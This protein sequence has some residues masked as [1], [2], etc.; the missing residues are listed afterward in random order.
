[1]KKVGT[2]RSSERG[3]AMVVVLVVLMALFV[4]CAPFLLTVRNADRASAQM[5]DRA[6]GRIAIDSATRHARANL[7]QSH[8]AIDETPYFDGLDELFVANEFP[9]AFLDA[10]DPNGV[11]WD[12]DVEDEAGRIDLNSAGPQ[13][14]AN[15]VGCVSRLTSTVSPDDLEFPVSSTAGFHE[16]GFFFVGAELI[17]FAERKPAV[18]G[19][20]TRE[21]GVKYDAEL[22]P[23]PCGPNVKSNHDMGSFVIDQRAFAIPD[24]R[25][26][27]GEPGALARFD[28]IEQVARCV[29]FAMAGELGDDFVPALERTT[30]VYGDV[31]AGARWFHG[32]KLMG[33]VQGKPDYGCV[34]PIEDARN[35]NQGTTVM[36][37]DGV[38]VE[39][40]L[41][42][43]FEQGQLRL[44]N[45]LALEYQ[46]FEA[47]IYP[48]AR[49]PVNVNTASPEVLLALFVNLKLDGHSSRITLSE[50]E[51]L[52]K[53]VAVSRP[54]TGFEDF[55]RRVVLPAAGLAALPKDAPVVPEVFQ[56]L[57]QVGE[58]K[59]DGTRELVGFLDEDDARALYKNALNANDVELE[60]STM[61]FSFTSRDV[62][63]LDLRASVNA[64]SGVERAR[65]SREEIDLVVPQRDLLH[66]WA[67]QEDFDEEPR[68]DGEAPG[69][70]TGPEAT[71]RFDRM[72][73]T[74]WPSRA[75]AHLGRWDT[76]VPI[77]PPPAPSPEGEETEPVLTFASREDGLAW[78]QLAPS[79]ED[80]R[81]A[82]NGRVLHFDDE[83]EHIEGRYLPF[84]TLTDP[85]GDYN[86][87]S[88]PGL[89]PITWKGWIQPR[90]LVPGDRFLDVGG[91]FTDSDRVSLFLE[92]GDLVLRVLDAMGDHPASSFEEFAEVRY[93]LAGAGP[94]LL[95]DVWSHVE[96]GVAGTRP[97]Q[98]RL[99]VDGR[100]S[101][102]TPGLTRLASTITS[103][104]RSIPVESTEG[105]PDRCVIRIGDE[106]IEVTK[107]GQGAFR[108]V[109]ETVGENAGFGGRLARERYTL[110][111][112][113]NAGLGK[114]TDHQRGATVQLYGYSLPLL[115]NVP[116]LGGALAEPI[117]PFAAARVVY[118]GAD[119]K[120]NE[121]IYVLD[122]STN[123]RYEI[124]K[125]LAG[126]QNPEVLTLE[127]IDGRSIEETMAAFSP[128]GGYAALLSR[129]YTFTGDPLLGGSPTF[130]KDEN[131][132][133][134]GGVEVIRYAGA[135]GSQLLIREREVALPNIQDVVDV[136]GR[137]A[138]V[139]D[140]QGSD[141]NE[142][143][144]PPQPWTERLTH[145][146][147]V[148][149]ISIPVSGA[150]GLSS[151]PFPGN[152][153]SEFVQIT[154]LGTDS[155][156]TEWVRYDE[157]PMRTPGHLVRDEPNALLAA[158]EA[159]HGGILTGESGLTAPPRGGGGQ[160]PN[161]PAQR[162]G[163]ASPAP[164]ST[165]AA[166]SASQGGSTYWHFALGEPEVE[167]EA[168]PA[169]R[170]IASQFQFR[171]VLGTWS[172]AHEKGA[173]VLPVWRTLDN[174]ETSGFPGRHD[175]V[176]LADQEPTQP[177][178]HAIVQHAHRPLEYMAHN[179]RDGSAG[180]LTSEPDASESAD[181]TGF[182]TL[183]IHVALQEALP[184]LF[185]ASALQN[186]I[187]DTRG[188]SRLMAFPSGER[189]RGA[190]VVAVGGDARGAL[191]GAGS[192]STGGG[193]SVPSAVVDELVYARD[194]RDDQLVVGNGNPGGLPT[195][196]FDA[197]EDLEVREVRRSTAGDV[198]DP[199]PIAGL[200]QDA[201]LLRI[202][203]EILCYD[204]YDA[205]A[206][207]LHFPPQGRG[208]LGTLPQTHM[209]GEGVHLLESW[210]VSVL[211]GQ[212]SADTHLVP[213]VSADDF[214]KEGTL[215]IDE[216]LLHFTHL[217]GGLL[218]MPRASLVPGERD[219]RGR[220]LF[221]GRF[222]TEPA[223][224]T[225][226]TPV[227]LFPFRYWDRWEP[228]ADDPELSY[229]EFDV[230][231]PD[232]FWR[233]VFWVDEDPPVSGTTLGVLQRLDPRV[234]WDAEPDRTKGLDLL[235]RGGVDRGGN[236]IGAQADRPQW[237]VFVRYDQDAFDPQNGRLHGWKTTPKLSLFGT[238]YLGPGRV[239]RR[240]DR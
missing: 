227:I 46:P 181:Q 196:F 149:P 160:P 230:D 118:A 27:A 89:V 136:G 93:A 125:G 83:T 173:Q 183:A 207:T 185:A 88:G 177:V 111:P 120:D 133:R 30:T 170:A 104:A 203:T 87:G 146:T 187:V 95:Q 158:N 43:S 113:Q 64:P 62:Y 54:F 2:W 112:E 217:E 86:W 19:G 240:V 37:T 7:G 225:V 215:L 212:M 31:G 117:G 107:D 223:A 4:L 75:K 134:I 8:R 206:N 63:R 71:S 131:D 29:E 165:P 237:R 56:Q 156:L 221:R 144:D 169:T 39:F 195:P 123:A 47:L 84:G 121:T 67:R 59:A 179:Y 3:V 116:N 159:A 161:P 119:K 153:G 122:R 228:L 138:F 92:D 61:P 143:D 22:M 6:T 80:D 97:D 147:L 238:E 205:D 168:F 142:A 36:I 209:P 32:V 186:Q 197:D 190:L 52:V 41:V 94:G 233:S 82:P 25:L 5:A 167:V 11:M 163:L 191:G 60:F 239:L 148:I 162:E 15:L 53:I 234:P 14:L 109:H 96:I 1:M 40:G 200:P 139:L 81:A 103:E 151:F 24:W 188:V 198:H 226:G 55:L 182:Q 69:W 33:E 115:T 106:L 224:H 38:N 114:D 98:M 44:W 70:M 78:I 85:A 204:G 74:P 126:V 229:F 10:S 77:D 45:E 99:I 216:E 154:R 12:L 108:A 21:L 58:L 65:R 137:G 50:A 172:H 28:A 76:Q 171:G 9:E 16:A 218:A 235:L 208:L 101:A 201:G 132:V 231:Q 140:W 180:P 34:L 145:Q 57:S 135:R 199:Q 66:V 210:R 192:R 49:R 219:G 72:F 91:L 194:T 155:H 124:G 102:R 213:V 236:P 73:E 214:P 23:L 152:G 110:D 232:A 18:L 220:G 68:L 189:P 184:V 150:T 130:D 175:H 79:R 48:Q 141:V 127:P 222:G 42:R 211:G 157:A 178:Y 51:E 20:L 164:A 13:M 174:D 129:R 176:A 128:S 166:G 17:G 193:I 90:A 202:G 100:W 35:F 26:R 105:F